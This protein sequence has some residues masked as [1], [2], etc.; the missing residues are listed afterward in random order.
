MT[1]RPQAL[2]L[3]RDPQ[4]IVISFP[5]LLSLTVREECIFGSSTDTRKGGIWLLHFGEQAPVLQSGLSGGT[6]QLHCL[7]ASR[8]V[9]GLH[10]GSIP[11]LQ[12]GL[13]P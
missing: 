3:T 5:E 10:L 7:L 1:K 6:D 12:V 8:T 9:Y 2:G 4:K 13:V 11:F